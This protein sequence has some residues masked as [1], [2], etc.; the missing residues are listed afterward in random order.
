MKILSPLLFYGVENALAEERR[1]VR[2]ELRAADP[3]MAGEGR[4][5]DEDQTCSKDWIWPAEAKYE[6]SFK[7][8]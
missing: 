7:F 8:P 6:G 5:S 2:E 1:R 4:G 3:L